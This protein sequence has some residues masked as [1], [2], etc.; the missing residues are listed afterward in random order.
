[1]S[2]G[3]DCIYQAIKCQR[4]FSF[5]IG[6]VIIS[7]IYR[8]SRS[9]RTLY[10]FSA[11]LT[12]QYAMAFRVFGRKVLTRFFFRR[13]NISIARLLAREKRLLAIRWTRC[14]FLTS[15]AV[16]CAI[17]S[18]RFRALT[19]LINEL[20]IRDNGNCG[21][22]NNCRRRGRRCRGFLCRF[23]FDGPRV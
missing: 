4:S 23:L 8:R 7:I 10:R 13:T 11:C 17:L 2:Y 19:G 14:P 21:G 16:I 20:N 6:V 12:S 22:M 9:K 15:R 5:V 3:G 18:G 1:M